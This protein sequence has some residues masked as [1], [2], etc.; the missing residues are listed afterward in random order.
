MKT[1]F[2]LPS[3]NNEPPKIEIVIST[4]SV[5]DNLENES[6]EIFRET[7][8][9]FHM[10]VMLYKIGKD[11]SALLPLA[12]KA[13]APAPIPFPPLHIDATWTF[14][15]MIPFRDV[16][17]KEQGFE[18]LVQTNHD[19][20]SEGVKPF[21]MGASEYNRIMKTL[22]RRAGLDKHGFDAAIGGPRRDKERS[23]AKEMI[24][25]A[26]EPGYRWDPRSLRPELSRTHNSK[27]APDQ[28]MR[29]ST[30]SDW[31]ELDIWNYILQEKN[32]VSPLYLAK[33]RPSVRRGNQI[34]LLG[35]ERYP[36][37]DGETHG[38]RKIRFRT[39]GSYPLIASVSS[40]A[41]SMGEV[42]REETELKPT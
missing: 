3:G 31:T 5:L 9:S 10:P 6:I 20:I 24:L 30:T 36:L 37:N 34:I 4:H 15:E 28:T 23:R 26:S 35:D 41:T 13:F 29:V 2:I 39:L 27:L 38:M 19:G 33:E 17:A 16:T 21:S 8:E 22:T 42:F 11:S 12:R 18:L 1:V 25:S 32:K 14:R 7:A 40:D